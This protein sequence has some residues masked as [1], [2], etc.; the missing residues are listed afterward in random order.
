MFD[1]GKDVAGALGMRTTKPYTNATFTKRVDYDG[2]RHR[3]KRAPTEPR[4]CPHCG[5][6]YA[7]RR[8]VAPGHTGLV[9]LA[10][11]AISTTCPACAAVATGVA[12]G[13]LKLEG[14]FVAA[15]RHEL[16]ALLRNEAGRA[17]DD[18]PTVRIM[19]WENGPRGSFS[20]A[21]TTEHLTQRLGH[22]LNRA[23]GGQI[24]YGFSHANKFARAVWR[25]DDGE[26]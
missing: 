21:T 6:V 11:P 1:L 15:H 19:R 12:R 2:G 13:H 17:A 10:A 18:N 23:F 3:T 26:S 4:Y 24:R 9:T 8:W 25:R 16:E 5:A 14:S 20:I 22:A 7:K